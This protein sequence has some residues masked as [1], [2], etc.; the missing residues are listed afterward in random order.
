MVCKK[1][2]EL[3]PAQKVMYIGE[4]VHCCQSDDQMFEFGEQIVKMGVMKGLFD[5]VKIGMEVTHNPAESTDV[6]S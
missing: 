4:I 2:E 6:I 3:T 5:G 1:F